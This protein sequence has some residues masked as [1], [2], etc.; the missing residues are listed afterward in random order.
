LSKAL[1]TLGRL[2]DAIVRSNQALALQAT[3]WRHH[4]RLGLVLFRAE[5]FDDAVRSIDRACQISRNQEACANLAVV[6]ERTGRDEEARAAAEDAETLAGNRWGHYNLA[7]YHAL[8]GEPRQALDALRHSV[9]LGFADLLI[10]T[11][12]DLEGLR[13]EPGFAE[14]EAAVEERL[15]LRRELSKSVFPWQA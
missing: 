1:E 5:Q 11:D 4:Q 3:W 6:L 10:S 14:L 15:N 7:C 9:D 8:A 2:D 13:G 12:S